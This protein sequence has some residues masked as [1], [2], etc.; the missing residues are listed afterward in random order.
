M[1]KIQR[2][3][4]RLEITTRR[5][6]TPQSIE[7]TLLTS[8]ELNKEEINNEFKKLISEGRVSADPWNYNRSTEIKVV[9]RVDELEWWIKHLSW[10]KLNR[11]ALFLWKVYRTLSFLSWLITLS[12]F[13]VPVL[14]ASGCI[15]LIIAHIVS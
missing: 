12:L 6:A 1:D 4:L 2:A 8:L 9:W 10:D 11:V 13:Y 3:V 5:Y 7:E 15:I 14:A